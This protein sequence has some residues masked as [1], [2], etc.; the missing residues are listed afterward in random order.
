MNDLHSIAEL[1]LQN[2][3]TGV[4]HLLK[5]ELDEHGV[6][7]KFGNQIVVSISRTDFEHRLGNLLQQIYR[8]VD[9][10]FPVREEQLSI[11]IRDAEA[12]Y[13]NTF[14]I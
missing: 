8:T 7:T 14:K 11:V 12:K 9:Q 3:S 1:T 2:L 13:E 10:H 6:V 5:N 4:L